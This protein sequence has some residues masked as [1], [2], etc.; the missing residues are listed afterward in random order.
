MQGLD[1]DWLILRPSLAYTPAGSFGGTSLLRAL[2]ALPWV[3]P[4]IGDGGQLFQPI[5]MA[6][7]CEAVRRLIE[8]RH[9]A[10]RVIDVVGPAPVALR[11]ILVGLR[12]SLGLVPAYHLAIPLPFVRMIA[13][14]ADRFGGVGPIT[15]TSLAMLLAGNAADPAPLVAATGFEPRRF[16]DALAAEPA[17]VQDRWHARLYFLRPLLRATIGLFF[18]CTGLSTFL[19]WPKADSMALLRAAGFPEA[20]LPLAYYAGWA[21]NVVLGL[22]LLVRWR[23]QA[24]GAVMV[25]AC[26]FYLVFVTIAA[27]AEWIY[28]I[29]PLGIVIP[30][31]VAI[32]V[33]I[34]IEDDR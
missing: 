31:M 33:M 8:E 7:L 9:V 5:H 29:T 34:A 30:L 18:L 12:R 10:R 13:H 3:I 11:D 26:F 22:A 4:L 16:A 32:L 2:A 15:S 17:H 14:V 28:P 23:V 6:D 19:F 25:A 20:T 1:L 21:F 24:V 27:P